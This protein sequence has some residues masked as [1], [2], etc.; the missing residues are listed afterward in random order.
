MSE[1]I[2][3]KERLYEIRDTVAKEPDF[4]GV[5]FETATVAL[6]VDKDR[7]P[8]C[9]ACRGCSASSNLLDCRAAH[10]RIRARQSR[11]RRLWQA[12]ASVLHIFSK[13]ER[14]V[15]RIELDTTFLSAKICGI[16]G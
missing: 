16:C 5:D 6:D 14:T 9:S 13:L 11:P 1:K 8:S 12:L 15:F 3:T 4:R 7:P 2:I 10:S